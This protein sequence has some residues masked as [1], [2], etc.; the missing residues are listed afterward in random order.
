MTEEKTREQSTI[1]R[2]REG[3]TEELGKERVGQRERRNRE[4]NRKRERIELGKWKKG[5]R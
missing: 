3:G 2:E 1:H 4:K 5:G